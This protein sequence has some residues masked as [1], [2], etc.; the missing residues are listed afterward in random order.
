MN[1]LESALK[2]ALEKEASKHTQSEAELTL[3]KTAAD[4]KPKYKFNRFYAVAACL[5]F[6]ILAAAIIGIILTAGG[7][8]IT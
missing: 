7:N 5:T 2:E 4:E 6:T 8:G 1:E 3:V